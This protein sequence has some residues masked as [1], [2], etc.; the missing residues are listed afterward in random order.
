MQYS[1]KASL[2]IEEG[3]NQFH[4]R[5]LKFT[6]LQCFVAKNKCAKVLLAKIRNIA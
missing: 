1:T 4:I 5:L 3:F 2:F 6:Y